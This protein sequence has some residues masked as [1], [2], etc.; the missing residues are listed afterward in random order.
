LLPMRLCR[1][2]IFGVV[3]FIFHGRIFYVGLFDLNYQKRQPEFSANR[4]L[5]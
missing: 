1:H 5:N 3:T 2:P 4:A